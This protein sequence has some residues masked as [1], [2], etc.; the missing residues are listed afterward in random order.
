M[1]VAIS[2]TS[3]LAVIFATQIR[4]LRLTIEDDSENPNAY[5]IVGLRF[6]N[7]SLDEYGG[8]TLQTFTRLDTTDTERALFIRAAMAQ[9]TG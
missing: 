1:W 9:L 7:V 8:G 2:V 6:L 5:R 3:P 4:R